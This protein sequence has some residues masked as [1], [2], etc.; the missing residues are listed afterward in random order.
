[1]ASKYTKNQWEIYNPIIPD[2]EQ[3]DSF[4]TKRKLDKME[5]GIEDASTPLE[6]GELSMSDDESFDATITQ[7]DDGTNKLNIKFPLGGKG[8]TGADGK[9]AYDIWLEQGNI[10]TEQEFLDYLKGID[11]KDGKD[12][13]DGID[14]EQGPAGKSAYQIWIDEGNTGS[15][16]DFLNSIQGPEGPQGPAGE[17]GLQGPVGEKG[18]TG[19][20]GLQG[21]QGE[22]G[23][24]GK[25]AYDI[26]LEQ[27]NTG[28]EAEFVTSLKGEKGDQGLQGPAGEQG[29]QG[30]PGPQG[31]EGP[32]G[33]DGKDGKSVTIL[34]TKD[35]PD[36][37][38]ADNNKIG[39]G[40]LINGELYTWDGTKW[41]NV[42]KIQG[43][44]GDKGDPGESG[45]DGQSAYEL[46]KSIPGNE[47]KT[48]TE[49]MDSLKGEKG[50]K[51]DPGSAS[52]IE[53]VDFGNSI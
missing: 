11:G 53:F 45:A 14:G 25:S 38:P 15:L 3:P 42:G 49:F 29:L 17:Q 50:E 19:E 28:S 16:E 10:G 30:E 24:D 32:A 12:G 47:N 26:W 9:S 41:D 23:A 37:L 27:G 51:G 52:S 13:K 7:S 36:E 2:K 8:A 6:I 44:K 35:S 22:N 33:Q 40:Y 48:I 21:P 43:P 1:M 5:Q 4:I 20:Q 39:D 46:W 18:E 31:P 34:G